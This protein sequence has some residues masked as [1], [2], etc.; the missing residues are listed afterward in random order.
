MKPKWRYNIKLAIRKGVTVR[1][2]TLNDIPVFYRLYQ[3]TAHRDGIAIHSESYYRNLLELSASIRIS[4]TDCT[5]Y[6]E[7]TLYLAE[8]EGTALASIITLFTPYEAVYLYGASSNE[9]RNVMPAYLLQWTAICDA[10]KY[11]SRYYDLYGIPP[12]DDEQHPMHGLYRFKTGFGGSLIHRPGSIDVK[13][14]FVYR[15]YRLGEQ[16]RIFWYK[17]VKKILRHSEKQR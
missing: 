11:G 7:V 14:S 5:Y 6:P 2:G 10:K 8:Y 3:E 1:K 15:W 9:N 12:S 17:K 16:M 4:I 13:L